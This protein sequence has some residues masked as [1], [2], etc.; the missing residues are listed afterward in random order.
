MEDLSYIIGLGFSGSDIW[1]AII[2]SFFAAMLVGKNRRIWIMALWALL[3]DRCLWPLT[4]MAISGA[5]QT[6][7]SASFSAMIE[8]FSTDMGLYVVRYAGLFFMINVFVIMRKRIH[9]PKSDKTKGK[10]VKPAYS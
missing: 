9:R 4:D 3:F 8:T 10:G 5:T 2:I 1:R 6:S 7:I